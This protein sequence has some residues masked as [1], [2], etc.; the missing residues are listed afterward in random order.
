M[1]PHDGTST[2]DRF[3][4]SVVGPGRILVGAA[5]NEG[6]KRLHVHK[7][8]TED[9]KT[10]KTILGFASSTNKNTLVDIWGSSGSEFTVKMVIVD[11][12]KGKTVAESEEVSSTGNKSIYEYFYPDETGVDCTVKIVPV[13][14]P[15]NGAPNI[16]VEA[17]VSGLSLI[18]ISEPTRRP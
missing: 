10:L 8:F 4:D 16:Y 5:G 14:N 17:Y 7:T 3:F 18:H 2:M 6:G 1:G 13:E 12:F 9:D 15:V 11:T